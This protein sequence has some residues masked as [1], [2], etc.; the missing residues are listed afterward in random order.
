MPTW[1]SSR[2]TPWSCAGNGD[3]TFNAVT[4][5]PLVG[6]G[7]DFGPG[8]AVGD[9][10]GDGNDDL[11]GFG[12]D[13]TVRVAPGAGDATFGPPVAID[14]GLAGSKTRQQQVLGRH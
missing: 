11:V 3:G 6:L 13:G 5:T 8:P 10:N 2:R 14:V 9:V 4:A 1:S 12:K 7:D